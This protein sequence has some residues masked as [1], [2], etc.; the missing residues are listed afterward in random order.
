MALCSPACGELW[1][2][3]RQRCKNEWPIFTSTKVF[4]TGI[5][6]SQIIDAVTLAA[7][8][9]YRL[10][11]AHEEDPLVML[12]LEP[13]HLRYEDEPPEG[14][15]GTAPP[16]L[17]R[18]GLDMDVK[19]DRVRAH[20]RLTGCRCARGHR[21]SHCLSGAGQ[22]GAGGRAMHCDSGH[23]LESWLISVNGVDI[24]CELRYGLGQG[25]PRFVTGRLRT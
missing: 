5:F 24:R 25:K 23:K 3:H 21:L 1:P 15:L 19:N 14:L 6:L 2:T 8:C 9:R 18:L 20:A 12:P 22:I 4:E 11:P 16:K 17:K 13:G 10:G 7:R